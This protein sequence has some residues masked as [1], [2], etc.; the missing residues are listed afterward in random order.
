LVEVG[1]RLW[2]KFQIILNRIFFTNTFFVIAAKESF[3]ITHLLFVN[4]IGPKKLY[5]LIGAVLAI[6]T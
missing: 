5:F 2:R 1:K 6:A 4:L 3:Q